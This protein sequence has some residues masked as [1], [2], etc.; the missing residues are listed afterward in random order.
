[1]AL[2]LVDGH[3]IAYRSYYAFIRNPL[4]DSKGRNTSAVYGFLRVILQILERYRPERMACVFDSGEET[5]RHRQYTEY[6]A[7]R[8]E[9][10]EEMAGQLPVIFELLEALGIPVVSIPGQ[11]ADDI[12][13]T[14]ARRAASSGDDV[15]IVTGDKDLFQLLSDRIRVIRPSSGTVLGDDEGPEALRERYGLEPGQMADLLALM[16]DSVDNIPGVKGIGEKTALKLI[17]SFGSLDAVLERS[18]EIEPEHVR[19]KI[20]QGREAALF[21]REL[22]TL[23]DVP[24]AAPPERLVLREREEERL[25]DLL[26]S[27]EFN[28]IIDE[29]GLGA[30]R[31]GVQVAYRAVDA[32]GLAQ[33]ARRLEDAGSFAL[34]VE[35]T[36]LDPLTAQLVGISFCTQ[37]GQAWYVPVQAPPGEGSEDLF[38]DGVGAAGVPLELV[39]E[40]LGAVLRSG[41]T[42][43]TGHNVK[44]DLI[45]LE[46][47][48]FE[49][50][51]VTWDTMIA[52]YCLDP[53]RRSHALD[54][55]A[56]DHFR[57]RKIPYDGLFEAGD[58]RRDIRR[59]PPERITQYACEDADYTLRLRRLFEPLLERGG[60]R[61]LFCEIE[62][63]LCFVL[64][65]MEQAGMAVDTGRLAG[66]AAVID[67]ELERISGEIHVL[68]GERFNINSGPQL[69]RVLFDKL[70]LPSLRRTKTGRSTDVGVLSELAVE[71]PIAALILEHRQL[72]KLSGTYVETL[73]GLVNPG[74]G[75]IH[76]SFNQTVTATGRLSSSEPNL[77]NIPI[78][79]QL[80]RSIRRA[81]VPAEGNLLLDA[82]YS[83]IELRLMAHLSRDAGL[84]EAFREEA[85]IHTRTAARIYGVS[86]RDVDAAMRAGA[87]T[88]NFGV[89][90]GQGPR[91]LSRQ[92]RI[93]FEEAQR[94][95]DEYFE[96]YPG[97]R[98]WIESAKEQARVK[99]YAETMLGRRR[100]L[101]DITSRDGGLRSFAERIAVNM[102]IQGSAADLIKI[103]M[104]AIDRELDARGLA[105]RMV[106][107]VHDE[108]V[109][110]VPEAQLPAVASLVREKM[111]S[112]VSLDVPLKIDLGTGGDWLEAHG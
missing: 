20:E 94:F 27:L 44:Y 72:T 11:E 35:T 67:G 7:Q 105:A 96:S 110:D 65:R 51:N 16:G 87:K 111:E 2:L 107:Q 92:L 112:A 91:A 40:R 31:R 4:L 101:P 39:R 15:R 74:T 83:Q 17:R 77:Q 22:V 32:D 42:Q 13:A 38:G 64:K 71:H 93:P 52:S 69:Q 59:V 81:F 97:V 43:K 1:M 29:L 21:S 23:R 70:G 84:I 47:H 55:L 89:L 62:M 95:I 34:D 9:M 76:T 46:R 33:L 37:E 49:V 30:A 98:D 102:P 19:R 8:E 108:L 56:L 68:A 48:G 36:S 79:T 57:Y 26:L 103:A 100:P 86:E 41:E 88:I 18:G 109:F 14:L 63:P 45:V 5:E 75:R 50:R 73:P 54:A 6:K 28:Q 78:R 24:E 106:L 25:L 80:G 99:G 58:R 53:S 61:E 90:Y 60:A 3:A 85:D 104:I 82:D 12:I 10:P 66:L